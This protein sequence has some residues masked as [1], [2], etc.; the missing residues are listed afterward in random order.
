MTIIK[1][2][3]KGRNGTIDELWNIHLE[4]EKKLE[5]ALIIWACERK[6]NMKIELLIVYFL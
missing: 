3:H 4:K 2:R 1:G 6:K 5:T